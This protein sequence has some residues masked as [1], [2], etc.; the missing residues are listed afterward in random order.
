MHLIRDRPLQA[1]T[2]KS[3]SNNETLF[4][5]ID[6][7]SRTCYEHIKQT[8][9]NGPYAL[10][11]YSLGTTVAFELAK[12]L[13][14]NGGT[15]AFCGALDSPPHLIPLVENLD[16]TAAAVLVSYVIELVPQVK[17]PELITALRGLNDDLMLSCQAERHPAF[18]TQSSSLGWQIQGLTKKDHD[19]RLGQ[20]RRQSGDG[21]NNTP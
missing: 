8:Q 14:A 2:A 4:E 1:L 10:T 3:P 18:E 12:P 9:H 13:E 6:E 15:V 20:E 21:T 17:V 11:G 7:M 19:L 16:G 5:S